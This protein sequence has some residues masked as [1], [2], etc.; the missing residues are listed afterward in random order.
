MDSMVFVDQ[1][2]NPILGIHWNMQQETGAG[3]DVTSRYFS[4]ALSMQILMSVLLVLT[5]VTL[6]LPVP[7]LLVA[8][9]VPVTRDTLEMV[10]LVQVSYFSL[11]NE[12]PCDIPHADIDECAV[13]ADNCDTNAAC[14]NTPGSFT[15]TCNQGYTGNGDTCVST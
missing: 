1:L 12:D 14:T 9:P 15:C 7:T 4:N 2:S 10:P 5:T 13:T 6:M 3:H 11:K 8:S